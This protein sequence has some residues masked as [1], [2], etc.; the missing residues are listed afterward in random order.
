MLSTF[1]YQSLPFQ[2]NYYQFRR[3]VDPE[4]DDTVSYTSAD[5]H[6]G[7]FFIEP[8]CIILWEEPLIGSHQTAHKRQSELTTMSMATEHQIDASINV[9]IKQ[10]R[11][12]R[13]QH[14][15][16]VRLIL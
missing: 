9:H 11:T 8:T 14:C 2:F 13:Q 4:W 15:K 10:L 3:I 5:D 1:S 12:V 7:V 6:R 16:V